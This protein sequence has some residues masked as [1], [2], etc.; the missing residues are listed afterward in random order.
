[1]FILITAV[2]GR[3]TAAPSFDTLKPVL[4]FAL[5]R[6]DYCN[7]LLYDISDGL[8]R[9][10]QS[11][12][13]AAACLVTAKIWNSLPAHHTQLLQTF[14]QRLQCYFFTCHECI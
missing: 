7:S 3:E 8:L 14:G 9:H 10:L 13:N 1:M 5:C 2:V 6:L 4:A 12:E 11:V